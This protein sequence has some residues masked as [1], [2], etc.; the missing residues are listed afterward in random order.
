MAPT[1]EYP[2]YSVGRLCNLSPDGEP[3]LGRPVGFPPAEYPARQQSP[4]ELV[5]ATLE[6]A[7]T[8]VQL[9]EGDHAA[10][11]WFAGWVDLPT[12]QVFAGLFNRARLVAARQRQ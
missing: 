9:D 5:L 2:P 6:E 8:G 10:I 1:K 12:A 7:L 3:L 11:R 4:A